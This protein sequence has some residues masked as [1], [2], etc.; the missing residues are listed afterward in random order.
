MKKQYES[1]F[2][3]FL[4]IDFTT[5][6]LEVSKGENN[7]SGGTVVDPPSDPSNPFENW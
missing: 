1:P 6:A 5:D 2:F 4:V 3:E 7:G